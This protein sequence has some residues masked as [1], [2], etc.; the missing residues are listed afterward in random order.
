M[1]IA[2]NFALI[3]LS[4][5]LAPVNGLVAEEAKPEP[6]ARTLSIGD[7]FPNQTYEDPHEAKHQLNPD[8]QYVLVSF[9]MEL[10]KGI[11]TWLSEKEPDYLEKHKM[12]YVSDITKMPS[13]I[14][15]L[16]ARPKMK[17]YKFPILLAK[18]EKFAPQFPILEGK[19][20]LFE[21]DDDRIVKEVRYF[22]DMPTLD[23]V[24]F[25]ERS[26]DADIDTAK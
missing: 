8:T 24:V 6:T 4:L 7:Q 12:Q 18:D 16:F 11:H 13:I 15:F 25:G 9:E 19:F 1:R 5:V 10:S 23:R 26:K 22:K 17:R 2:I 20:A 14:T 21:L 3:L